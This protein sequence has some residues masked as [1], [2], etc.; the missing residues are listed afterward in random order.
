MGQRELEVLG[1]ELFDVGAADGVGLLDLDNLEDLED[2]QYKFW[3]E[4]P[5]QLDIRGWSR[6]GH[7]DGQPCPGREPQQPRFWTSHGTPCTCCG[8]RSESRSGS[9]YRSS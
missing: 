3:K 4:S 6:S 5:V 7:G 9:R 2:Y 1:K 8:Y